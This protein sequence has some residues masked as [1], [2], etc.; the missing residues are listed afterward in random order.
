MKSTI[1]RRQSKIPHLSYSQAL[2]E[3]D[4]RQEHRIQPGLAR[5]QRHLE[6]LGNPQKRFPAVHVA[7]TNGKGSVCAMLSSILHRAGFCTGLFTS[8]HLCGVRER[9]QIGASP[10]GEEDFARHL[11]A[12]CAAEKRTQ[13]PLTYF[14]L[15]A[16]IAFQYFAERGVDLAII[17]TGMGGRF[18]A[19]NV[20]EKPLA[21]LL[22]SL[23][24]DHTDFLGHSLT[25]IAK[26]KAGILKSS[27]PAWTLEV[28]PSI[29]RVLETAARAVGATLKTV[30]PRYFKVLAVHWEKGRQQIQAPSGESYSLSLLGPHQAQNA[31]L[32]YCAIQHLR[33]TGWNI[34]EG[35][36][37]RGFS[38]ISWPCRFQVLYPHPA[39]DRP[40]ILDI[41][42]NPQAIEHLCRTLRISPWA[43]LPKQILAG[44]LKD[45]DVAAMLKI[46]FRLPRLKRCIFTSPQSPR[47][48]KASALLE[49]ARG[50]L[51]GP[52]PNSVLSRHSPTVVGSHRP[53]SPILLE[54]ASHPEEA[55]SKL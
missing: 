25:H 1:E 43:N 48:L 8:P 33:S 2:Q 9:I 40:L 45:K 54:T 21:C 53:G 31:G 51:G 41:A 29:R 44:F 16:S 7:G 24:L 11:A 20:L 13:T 18:D 12:A 28:R 34:P 39:G 14:E 5:I 37:R 50:L 42:H 55:L 19:T 47:A 6:A 36:L 15:T 3:L 10:I 52:G 46:L 30:P 32:A 26:E 35:A 27:S 4:A 22:T 23:G 38:E 17:E 49:M